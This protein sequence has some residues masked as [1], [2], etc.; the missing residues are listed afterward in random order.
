MLYKHVSQF[1]S[2]VK[3]NTK[4]KTEHNKSSQNELKVYK[5]PK[6]SNRKKQH[7]SN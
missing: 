6:I 7:R 4:S 1:L 5:P 3:D 2:R